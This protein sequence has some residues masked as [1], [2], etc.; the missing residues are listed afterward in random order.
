MNFIAPFTDAFNMPDSSTPNFTDPL[1]YGHRFDQLYSANNSFVPFGGAVGFGNGIH[2]PFGYTPQP[3]SNF[4]QYYAAFGAASFGAASFG[5]FRNNG[6]DFNDEPNL[7]YTSIN[8]PAESEESDRKNVLP[9]PK[10]ENRD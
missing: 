3:S 7:N 6:Y 10:E 1:G 9:L 8:E 5:P 4:G 2:G